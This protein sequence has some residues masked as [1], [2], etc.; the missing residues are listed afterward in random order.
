[1]RRFYVSSYTGFYW[2]VCDKSYNTTANVVCNALS[3]SDARMIATALN[4]MEDK[5]PSHNKR[6]TARKARPKSLK[7]TS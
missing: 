4:A 5:I 1:M 6:I 2:P 7:A 3:R